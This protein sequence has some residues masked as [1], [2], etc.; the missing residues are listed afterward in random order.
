MKENLQQSEQKKA[1]KQTDKEIKKSNHLLEI[2]CVWDWLNFHIK[3]FPWK[4]S[5]K[6][7][8][9]IKFAEMHPATDAWVIK[10][11]GDYV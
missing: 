8:Y 2:N 9:F 10:M 4:I 5:T 7:F 3:C 6:E 11:I 1:N